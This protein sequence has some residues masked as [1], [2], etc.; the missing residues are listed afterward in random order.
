MLAGCWWFFGVLTQP[1]V[2]FLIAGEKWIDCF[3]IMLI[4]FA[5]PGGIAV[6]F[7][8]CLT[9]EKT[10]KNIKANVGLLVSFVAL[11]LVGSVKL[12]W[13]L[14]HISSSSRLL[15]I[16]IVAILIYIPV[17]RF[18]M[19]REGLI[20][21]PKGEFVG[22]GIILIIAVQIW[23]AGTEI[24]RAYLPKDFAAREWIIG[25]SIKVIAP[26]L[27]ALIFYKV[28]MKF[29]QEDK[30]EQTTREKPAAN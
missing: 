18:L 2:E 20:P 27:I 22:K 29:I 1:L 8:F 21:K 16:T 24:A 13:G 28:A 4:L 11:I 12:P 30:T 7:G 17:S 6:C 15:L 19:L 5:A 10:K 25:D 14:N 9:K 26:I 23:L 3:N